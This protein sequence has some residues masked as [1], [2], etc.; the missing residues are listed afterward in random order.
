MR[1]IA[2]AL[3]TVVVISLLRVPDVLAGRRNFLPLPDKT[4]GPTVNVSVVMEGPRQLP[5]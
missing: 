1:R 4:L 5:L 2:T 3:A